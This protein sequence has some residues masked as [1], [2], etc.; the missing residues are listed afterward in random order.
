M[1]ETIVPPMLGI[2]AHQIRL[3][4][5]VLLTGQARYTADIDVEGLTHAAF[6][7]S[8]M[9]HARIT[10][11]DT[12][13]ALALDGV[14]AVLTDD[15]LHLGPVFFPAFAQLF[16]TDAFHRRPLTRDTVRFVGD[17][18]A[19]VIAESAAIATDG[20]ELVEVDYE[21]IAERGRP[22]GSRRGRRP[23]AVPERRYQ[24]RRRSAVQRGRTAAGGHRLR[25]RR[26]D[27]PPNGSGADGGQRRSSPSPTRRAAA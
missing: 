27:E 4:D 15:D 18:I 17:V 22:G 25:V 2:G 7:R 16:A 11:V 13:A 21:P 5:P 23:A 20:A 6:V 3:E 10:R 1:T 9:A 19:I 14:L 26:R 12:S 24:R 8:P